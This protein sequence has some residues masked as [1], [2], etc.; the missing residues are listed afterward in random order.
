MGEGGVGQAGGHRGLQSESDMT[1]SAKCS[2]IVII[3][4]VIIPITIIIT[5]FKVHCS[6][7]VITIM[8]F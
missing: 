7:I 1:Q 2:L 5:I 6:L 3:I 4:L 8:D